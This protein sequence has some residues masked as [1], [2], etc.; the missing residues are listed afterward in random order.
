MKLLSELSN[1]RNELREP[2]VISN[3]TSPWMW[4]LLVGFTVCM[5]TVVYWA[6]FGTLVDSVTGSGIVVRD[7]GISSITAKSSGTV[8]YLD[9]KP[10]SALV[11][12]QIIGRIYNPEV[13]FN[14]HKLQAEQKELLERTRK[15]QSGTD[16][17]FEKRSEADKRKNELI[18]H[19]GTLMKQNRDRIQELVEMQRKLSEK[20]ITTKDDHYNVL[21]ENVSNENQL[22]NMLLCG[23]CRARDHA[24]GN[25]YRPGP[26]MC[27]YFKNGERALFESRPHVS[28]VAAR[29]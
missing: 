28:G 14:I 11:P 20:G 23:G 8:E 13:F 19:L 21:S 15:L 17:L 22:A 16:E 3:V 29:E 1:R 25:L 27:A 26:E 24:A 18:D 7:R 9:I 6:F 12:N 2:D 5:A 4:V 10:G